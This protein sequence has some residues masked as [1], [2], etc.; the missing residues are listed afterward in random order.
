MPELEKLE[1]VANH[2][3]QNGEVVTFYTEENGKIVLKA[4]RPDGTIE[5]VLEGN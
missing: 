3:P 1:D 2:I 4:K 5:T